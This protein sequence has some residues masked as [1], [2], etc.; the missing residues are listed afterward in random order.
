MDLLNPNIER[1]RSG[2]NKGCKKKKGKKQVI[3]KK[4]R[5]VSA[6]VRHGDKNNPLAL[7]AQLA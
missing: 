5:R 1:Q 3:I 2:I 6:M 7:A 4:G